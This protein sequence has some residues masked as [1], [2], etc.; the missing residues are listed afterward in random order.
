[1]N[2]AL[3]VV[4]ILLAVAFLG[5]G[6]L[7]LTQPKDMVAT[8]MAWAADVRPSTIK[9]HLPTRARPLRRTT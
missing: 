8:S 6:L 3:W 7:K 4:R 9:L 2:A 1:M 5:S